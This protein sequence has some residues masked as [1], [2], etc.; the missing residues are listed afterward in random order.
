MRRR[1]RTLLEHPVVRALLFERLLLTASATLALAAVAMG[2]VRPAEIAGLLDARLLALFFVLTIAVELGKASDLF[3]RLVAAVVRRA[4]H[5]RAL[6]FALVGVTALCAALLT[7][8]VALMLVVP[9]TML[10]RKVSDMDLAPLVVLEVAAANLLGAL[11]PIGNPQNLFLYTRGGFTPARFLAAQL[12]FVAG[13]ALLLAAAVPLLVRRKDFEPPEAAPFDVDPILAAGFAVLLLAVV[14]ALSGLL[15]WWVP[16][17]LSLLGAGL[18]GRRILETDFSLVFVFAF[19]FVGVAGLERGRLYHALDPER[20]FGHGPTGLLVSG[21][22][23][24]QFVSNVPA[25]MLL[26]P[27]VRSP[28]GFTALLYGV[29]AGGCG[30]PFSSLANLIGGALFAREGG[31]SGSFWRL[32][33]RTSFAF[34]AAAV[35]WS[36]AVVRLGNR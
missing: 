14:A 10:F 26:A 9:F 11:T 2:L 35:A 3:D 13:G 8:D 15:S 28:Q 12:P 1:V 27:A 32:F 30:T 23:L 21:A 24:S 18:L 4:R 5:S 6:A 29:N 36:L 22:L 31:H 7:N 16:L 17:G 20:L 34:L 19:L 25:A 33:L